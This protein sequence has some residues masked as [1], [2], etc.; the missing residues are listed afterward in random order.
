MYFI[1]KDSKNCYLQSYLQGK[2]EMELEILT[3]EDAEAK[4]AGRA[5]EEPNENPHLKD[6]E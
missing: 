3:K 2:I 4:P 6:P 1:T 5:R